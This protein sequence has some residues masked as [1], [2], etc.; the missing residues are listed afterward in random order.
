MKTPK[1]LILP[2]EVESGGGTVS[3]KTDCET[4][5][6]TRTSYNSSQMKESMI[7][8]FTFNKKKQNPVDVINKWKMNSENGISDVCKKRKLTIPYSDRAMLSVTRSGVWCCV[9]CFEIKLKKK[10]P[11]KDWKGIEKQRI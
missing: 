4:N 5:R 7:F 1:F 9:E 10:I 2:S 3:P 8:G 6:I 11:E